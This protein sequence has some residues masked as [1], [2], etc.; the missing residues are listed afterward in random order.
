[1]CVRNGYKLDWVPIRTIYPERRKAGFRPLLDTLRFLWMVGL[2]WRR[3]RRWER[4][5]LPVRTAATSDEG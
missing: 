1:M 2:L 4:S 3:R 5:E